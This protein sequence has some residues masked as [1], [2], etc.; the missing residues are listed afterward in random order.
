VE[1]IGRYRILGELGRGGMGVVY[2][3]QDPTIGRTVAIKTIRFSDLTDPNERARLHER[4]FREAQSAGILSHPNIVTIYDIL[5]QAGLAYIFMEVV[6]GPTLETL[7][8]AEE[9]LPRETFFAI[10]RQTASA[11]DYAHKKGIVHRDIK[12]AN[13]MIHDDGSAKITDF[14]V[15]RIASSQMTQTGMMMGTPSYMSPEQV[16]GTTIDGRADQFSLAVIA[17]NVLTGEKPFVADYLPTLLYKIVREDFIAPQRINPT[18]GP[19]VEAVLRRALAKSPDDRYATCTDF[20]NDLETACNATP[21]WV[22]IAAGR[23][24]VM[25]TVATPPPA[26]PQAPSPAEPVRVPT[27]LDPVT[28]PPAAPEPPATIPPATP[29]RPSPQLTVPAHPPVRDVEPSHTVRNVV[30]ALAAVVLV[31]VVAIIAQRRLYPPASPTVVSE[32]P[33][34]PAVEPPAPAKPPPAAEAEAK[35]SEPLAEQPAEPRPVEAVPAGRPAPSRPPSS[36]Q[37]LLTEIITAP[38]GAKVTIDGGDT[39]TSPCSLPL[40]K[41]R[42]TIVVSIDGHRD[43]RRVF[44]VP[45]DPVVTVDLQRMT[46]A[47]SIASTPP[48]ATILLNGQ[49]RPEKT[50]AVLRL[51]IGSYRLQIV[52]QDVRTDEETI[53]VTDGGMAQRR[54]TLQ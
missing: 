20:V 3:A 29:P 33:S 13:I 44:S 54:Y 37:P 36:P 39:C 27:A 24:Q 43:S 34:T 6:N 14:G 22:A 48:G 2:K 41:G 50:P 8:A 16:Q 17:Y 26:G 42:H 7:L 15:A 45:E 21:G 52:H 23:S 28:P 10:L 47:L 51:P 40:A 31:G 19:A 9:A 18:L 46:G 35:K 32:Q 49:A 4:L 11:L 5:E 53:Q 30:L 1:Q 38:G 25:P 12:P